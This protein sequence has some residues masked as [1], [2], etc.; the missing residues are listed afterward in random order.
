MVTN[1]EN[2]YAVYELKE[3]ILKITFKPN[4]LIDNNAARLIVKDRLRFQT[5]SDY[6]VICDI[7]QIKRIS[8]RARKYLATNGSSLLKAV[9]LIS[10]ENTSFALANYYIQINKP[11]VLTKVFK[12]VEQ[13]EEFLEQFK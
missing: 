9:A 7:S 3:D 5:Y 10:S 8:A 12:K 2:D 11:T 1:Y 6:F 13:G 4:I